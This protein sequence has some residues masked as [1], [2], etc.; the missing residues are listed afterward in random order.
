MLM[1]DYR[2]AILAFVLISVLVLGLFPKQVMAQSASQLQQ[3][4]QEL[5]EQ[6]KEAA[7]EISRLEDQLD[8]QAKEVEEVSAQKDLIDQEI[9]LLYSQLDTINAQIATLELLLADTQDQLV[10]AQ[11]NLSQLN[12]K[13]KTRIRAMEEN[14]R[15]S[16]WSVLFHSASFADFLDRLVIVREIAE[17]DRRRLAE[18]REAA[19]VVEENKQELDSQMD[20]LEQTRSQLQQTQTELETKKAN[21]EALLAQLHEEGARFQSLLDA[22]EEAQS[23]LMEKIAEK[24][25][26]YEE[27]T[28]PPE[29]TAPSNDSSSSGWLTPIRYTAFTSPFGNRWHP[30]SGVWRMHYG[31]DL[32]APTGT[33]IV[34][35]RSGT[36]T[37]TSYEEGGA[38]YYVSINHG[39]GYASIYMH[40]THYIVAPGQYVQAGQTIGY[41]GSTGASTGPHLHFGIS[42][43]GSYVNPANYISI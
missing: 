21:A 18:M 27:A 2:K 42:Y 11:A 17:A 15:L 13:N 26:A 37:T 35:S 41:C 19:K 24:E 22:S 43:N 25:A 20:A 30:V 28:R 31:V 7:A 6:K 8:E 5:E 29:P 9:F 33:P 12:Q 39:D 23:E 4:L 36:V 1:K 16:Y 32:A 14:G 40:M 34:A 3:E 38:G 10:Q